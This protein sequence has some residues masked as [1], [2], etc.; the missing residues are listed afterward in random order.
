MNVK[1]K[2][3]DDIINFF[4][5]FKHRFKI[6]RLSVLMFSRLNVQDDEID[7]LRNLLYELRDDDYIVIDSEGDINTDVF[8]TTPDRIKRYR[9]SKKEEQVMISEKTIEYL[10]TIITGDSGKSEYKTGPKLIEFFNQFGFSDN[11][12]QG[13][14]PRWFF[15]QE[16]LIE[17]NKKNKIKDV[18]EN[19]YNPVNF[20]SENKKLVK[21]VT[22]LNKY[23][24]FDN[25]KLEITNKKACLIQIDGEEEVDLTDESKEE[26]T[27]TQINITGNNNQLA[28]DNSKVES[29]KNNKRSHGV[30]SQIIIGV[31]ILVVASLILVYVFGIK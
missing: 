5:K 10:K 29:V 28:N 18:I 13:F 7:H 2:T 31:I 4:N 11:Y 24:G 17:L 26:K 12:G 25:L 1:C 16:K 15:T 21:L 19:Y 6:I 23:L 22:E 20:I 8:Y 14:P 3:K 30:F 9:D 27:I